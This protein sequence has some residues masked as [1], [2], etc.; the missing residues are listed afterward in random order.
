MP[1]PPCSPPPPSPAEHVRAPI[2]HHHLADGGL[3]LLD[4]A[5][6]HVCVEAGVLALCPH[7]LRVTAPNRGSGRRRQGLQGCVAGCQGAVLGGESLCW[8][9]ERPRGSAAM[10]QGTAKGP[11]GPEPPADP[12]RAL[13][14][15]LLP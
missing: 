7:H 15:A 2:W 5:G 12:S 13:T 10:A 4:H 6:V 14:Q 1:H 11:T 9:Q 8:V 3:D